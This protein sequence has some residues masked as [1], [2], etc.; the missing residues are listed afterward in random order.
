MRYINGISYVIIES[1]QKMPILRGRGKHGG[2]IF[3][4]LVCN[5]MG[6]GIYW[7]YIFIELDDG[8][9]YR[10]PPSLMVKTMV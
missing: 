5:Y 6:Y 3:G 1:Y 10:K 7:I 8:K 2:P 4:F 9:I